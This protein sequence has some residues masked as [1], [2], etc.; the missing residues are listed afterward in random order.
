[1]TTNDVADDMA[2]RNNQTGDASPPD[3]GADPVYERILT[4][5]RQIFF[6]RGFARVTMA[7]L[8]HQLGISTRTLYKHFASK[9]D[10]VRAA[11]LS[12]VSE[13]EC[14]IIEA[15]ADTSLSVRDRLRKAIPAM[16]RVMSALEPPWIEDVARHAPELFELA[17]VR[18]LQ[19]IQA[20]LGP[21]FAEAAR[22]GE[23]R[24]NVPPHLFMEVVATVVSNL[25][26][27]AGVR[28]LQMAPQ[29]MFQAVMTILLDGLFLD[30]P[31]DG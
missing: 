8:A 12:K 29:Y 30:P 9:D 2:Q 21:L 18:R 25:L 3:G 13:M 23:T 7:E 31:P 5:A 14:A 15:T 17:N 22:R 20:H 24:S 6:S 4:R 10:L 28:R 19:C 26:T 11:M 16:V 27:P 1:M